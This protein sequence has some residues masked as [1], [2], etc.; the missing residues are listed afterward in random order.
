[1]FSSIIP[2]W[3][4]NKIKTLQEDWWTFIFSLKSSPLGTSCNIH[5]PN[6]PNHGFILARFPRTRKKKE[7]SLVVCWD[8][9]QQAKMRAL[10]SFRVF[11]S[12]CFVLAYTSATADV[13]DGVLG[14]TASC[15]KTC[16]M[17]YSLHTYP[18]VSC[19]KLASNVSRFA[20]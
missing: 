3:C 8:F 17:T 18:R 19:C 4:K 12:L 10:K 15:H 6:I 5:D 1:M 7:H 9:S 11:V 14:N 20:S 2:V 16:Q 13:F